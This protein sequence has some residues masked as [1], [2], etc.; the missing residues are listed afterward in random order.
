MNEATKH[1]GPDGSR[2]WVGEGITL[3]HNR[4]AIIDL[5]D[6]AL[7][8]MQTA[9]ARFSIVFNGEIYNYR[10]LRKELEPQY[11]FVTESDT[12]VLLVAYRVWGK[13]MLS[14]LRG[15]FAFGIWDAQT[16]ELLLARDHMGVKPLYYTFEGGVLS[17]SSELSGLIEGTQKKI[18]REGLALFA[19]IQYVPSEKTLVE[20]V[21]K[22][23]PG[24]FL[25]Y[26][27][28]TLEEG[29]FYDPLSAVGVPAVAAYS[30]KGLREVIGA[31]VERQLVSDRPIGTFLS[32]G[33][34][35][36]IVLH[37]M[38]EHSTQVRTFSVDFEMVQGAESEREKFNTDAVLAER[39]ANVYGATHKTFTLSI[40]DVRT[41]LETALQSLDEPVANPTAIS[42]YLLSKWV[43][44]AGVVVALG[45]DGGDELFG[46]Y[47]RHR[48]AMAA[49][50]FQQLP[51]LVRR[52]IGALHARTNKLNIEFPIP[53]HMALM[54]DKQALGHAVFHG[55]L[56]LQHTVAESLSARY[57]R[58]PKGM[59]PVD[60]FM[61]VDR[62]TWL[63]DESLAR[64][65]R[66]SMA[67]GLELRVPLLDLD[68]VTCADTISVYKK[69]D[70]FM[71]KK[72]LRNAYRGILPDYLF[73]QPKR[74]WVS[75]GAKWLRDPVI[76]SFA[77]EVLS[78]EYYDGL[79]AL[80][81][82][83]VIQRMYEDHL[84]KRGYYLYPLWNILVLQVWARK[85]GIKA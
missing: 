64:S 31:A 61:R 42:Q 66:S 58:V 39:T 2:V 57:A 79:D 24:H 8:P 69:T 41:N 84:E 14:K 15:I 81:N 46:G 45:G 23:R 60:A 28:G 77:Q 20:G 35:S 6:R 83:P 10:E 18:S 16:H 68:V 73:H 56:N 80:L 75:P 52:G 5:S 50:Y 63:P 13:E 19:A 27:N 11:T 67:H 62:E 9:D 37:H 25:R 43:R 12:E 65:D 3:G 44:D 7:Q 4:L 22:L 34:D 30:Q 40:D 85:Q 38:S 1:R 76:K 17:F 21:C 72:V 29:V 82:W 26:T 51:H 55:N 49:Y 48:M 47:T 53:L 74:G 71:G 54:V 32:G 70:P 33:L 59:H 78:P 36:S